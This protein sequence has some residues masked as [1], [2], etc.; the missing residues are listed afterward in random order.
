[1]GTHHQTGRVTQVPISQTI[2]IPPFS[3]DINDW[4]TKQCIVESHIKAINRERM[5]QYSLCGLNIPPWDNVS[6]WKSCAGFMVHVVIANSEV[7]I[8]D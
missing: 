6:V 7:Y 1:M 5:L 2:L 8:N 4:S 3:S